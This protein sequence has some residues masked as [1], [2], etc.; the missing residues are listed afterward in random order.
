MAGFCDDEPRSPL[1]RY[2]SICVGYKRVVS[3]LER[4][5]GRIAP[6]HASYR[7]GVCET[8]TSLLASVRDINSP[9]WFFRLREVARKRRKGE[10]NTTNIKKDAY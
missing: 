2:L 1:V 8:G 3:G 4:A 10:G 6:H 5:W 7:F 9:S